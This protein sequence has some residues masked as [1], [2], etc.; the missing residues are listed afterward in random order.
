VLLL[1]LLLFLLQL[2]CQVNKQRMIAAVAA[3]LLV[4]RVLNINRLYWMVPLKCERLSKPGREDEQITSAQ[5]PQM[6]V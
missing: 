2:S 6:H 1:F 3:L 4:L 5:L